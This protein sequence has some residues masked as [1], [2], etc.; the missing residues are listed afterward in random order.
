MPITSVSNLLQREVRLPR[1]QLF[2][3]FI[4]WLGEGLNV[5]V[6]A[7]IKQIGWRSYAQLI[8]LGA[9]DKQSVCTIQRALLGGRKRVPTEHDDQLPLIIALPDEKL[10]FTELTLPAEAAGMAEKAVKLRLDEISPISAENVAIAFGGQIK[11]NDGRILVKLAL[12]RKNELQ[13][14]RSQYSATNIIQMGAR[15]DHNGVLEYEFRDVD[16]N[17]QRNQRAKA[18]DYGVLL[19]SIFVLSWAADF[20]LANRLGVLEARETSLRETL[21]QQRPL[22][23]LFDEKSIALLRQHSSRKLQ[24]V[25]ELAGKRAATLPANA[26]LENVT[27]TNGQLSMEG[28]ISSDTVLATS[29][30][31]ATHYSPNLRPG[32]KRFNIT[33]PIGGAE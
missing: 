6:P 29:P 23:A 13:D 5:F 7:Q 22:L 16:T 21:R 9:D 25:L 1:A 11:G 33:Y 32:Y 24:S 3:H 4:R 17:N 2:R 10:F 18:F 31:V 27:F 12:A 30:E 20:H 26:R 19:I 15:A 14:L 28:L 8:E